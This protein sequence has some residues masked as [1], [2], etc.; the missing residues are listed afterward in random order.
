MEL[1]EFCRKN[2]HLL[3]DMEDRVE[4]ILYPYEI[5]ILNYIHTK[6]YTL[7]LKSRRMNISSLYAL[8]VFWF[9]MNNQSPTNEI[10]VLKESWN[11][12]II[13]KLSKLDIGFNGPI[14]ATYN[15]NQLRLVSSNFLSR[16]YFEHVHMLI[17][18]D[19]SNQESVRTLFNQ[20]SFQ[21]DRYNNAKVS[22]SLTSI[23][24]NYFR[25]LWE[26]GDWYNYLAHYS[27]NPYW[28]YDIIMSCIDDYRDDYSVW[29]ETMDCIRMDSVDKR[30]YLNKLPSPTPYK[31]S[32]I[33][34]RINSLA[35]QLND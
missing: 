33:I 34:K 9:M 6:D 1:I 22:M 16:T 13:T 30:Y 7:I 18:D 8:Y 2:F 24:D 17:I 3:F 21:L 4:G 19:Y 12:P 20:I 26:S 23:G 15:G 35:K 29:F 10:I 27:K 14:N 32:T 28:T 31:S 25:E 11:S 5:D